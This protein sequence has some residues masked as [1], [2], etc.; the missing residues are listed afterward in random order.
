MGLSFALTSLWSLTHNIIS[1]LLRKYILQFHMLYLLH[2]ACSAQICKDIPIYFLNS[3]YVHIWYA[4]SSQWKANWLEGLCIE[5]I[6][7]FANFGKVP[8]YFLFCKETQSS[9]TKSWER[10]NWKLVYLFYLRKAKAEQNIVV[11]INFRLP[12]IYKKKLR[13]E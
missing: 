2:S 7:D 12:K 6:L 4:K 1:M 9:R 11:A 8:I 5:V 3:R 10:Y 13:K